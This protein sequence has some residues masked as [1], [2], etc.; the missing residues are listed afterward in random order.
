VFVLGF[1]L[2]PDTAGV[3]VFGGKFKGFAY[4][5]DPLDAGT[6][7]EQFAEGCFVI[8]RGVRFIGVHITENMAVDIHIQPVSGS[9]PHQIGK[10]TVLPPRTR[11]ESFRIRK[12]VEIGVRMPGIY[13][14]G[15]HTAVGAGFQKIVREGVQF[16][17]GMGHAGGEQR[18]MFGFLQRQGAFSPE[19]E[20][21]FQI[22]DSLCG[23]SFGF[24]HDQDGI[25][26][27]GDVE[28][29][30]HVGCQRRGR[31]GFLLYQ[32]D[33]LMRCVQPG[34][35]I[36]HPP[37]T[38]AYPEGVREKPHQIP[39]EIPCQ[40][41]C[42]T[43]GVS[44]GYRSND[45]P[46]LIHPAGRF[47]GGIGSRGKTGR[48]L[49]IPVAEIVV[50]CIHKHLM[51]NVECRMQNAE[52]V[53]GGG[54]ADRTEKSDPFCTIYTIFPACCQQKK[55]SPEKFPRTVL[56]ICTYSAILHS[57]FCILN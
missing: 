21:V 8:G 9:P 6:C 13:D 25:L 30:R 12:A 45:F 46:V 17:A 33:L 38:Q 24:S 1:F 15:V 39:G 27:N 49:K 7:A 47:L 5:N 34:S 16:H 53:C 56:Q 51:E 42:G 44:M 28:G 40:P 23:T 35:H 57:D 32:N 52:L 18:G 2:D 4:E 50:V 31:D 54:Q 43:V 29:P 22:I 19:P 41:D 37:Q 14:D 3:G 20:T 10:V 26:R 11:P 36:V 48:I 55:N